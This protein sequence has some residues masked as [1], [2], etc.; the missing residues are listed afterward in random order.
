MSQRRYPDVLFRATRSTSYLGELFASRYPAATRDW[1]VSELFNKGLGI[2]DTARWE[3][4]EVWTERTNAYRANRALADA[5][6]L[7]FP[8]VPEA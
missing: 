5:V 1:V 2:N 3:V 4:D 6:R 8:P 7:P